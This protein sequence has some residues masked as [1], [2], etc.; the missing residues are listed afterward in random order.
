MEEFKSLIITHWRDSVSSEWSWSV[1]T[2]KGMMRHCSMSG[3]RNEAALLLYIFNE[4]VAL[5]E[6]QGP[7]TQS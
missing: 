5:F 7:E 3:G 1:E 4:G 2:N 6:P